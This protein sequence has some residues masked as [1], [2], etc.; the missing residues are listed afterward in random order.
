MRRKKVSENF[1]MSTY[2]SIKNET[3]FHIKPRSRPQCP[4]LIIELSSRH[5]CFPLSNAL[6]LYGRALL[7]STEKSLVMCPCF[8]LVARFLWFSYS[9]LLLLQLACLRSGAIAE[10][11]GPRFHCRSFM[12]SFPAHQVNQ[13]ACK[14]VWL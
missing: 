4:L 12:E 10:E 13:S 9:F 5:A 8:V 14:S 11:G 2:L 3:A 7:L 6:V 1:L